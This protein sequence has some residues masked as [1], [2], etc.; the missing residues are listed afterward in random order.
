VT[1]LCLCAFKKIDS[2]QNNSEPLFTKCI[3]N[4]HSVP[5]LY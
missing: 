1:G 5:L 3:L 2:D 4:R